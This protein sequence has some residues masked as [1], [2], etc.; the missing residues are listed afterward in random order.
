VIFELIQ[1]ICFGSILS[2]PHK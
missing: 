2:Y 1:F